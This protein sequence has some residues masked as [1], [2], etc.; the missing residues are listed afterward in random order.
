MARV[1]KIAKWAAI[2]IGG[3][4]AVMIVGGWIL[5]EPRPRGDLGPEADAL[6]SRMEEAVNVEAYE[7]T[8][9]IRWTFAGDHQHLWD[10][11][12]DVARVRWD[13]LEALVH[14]GE[15]SGRVY[16]DGREVGGAEARALLEDAHS[17]FINDSFWLNPIAKLRDRGVT[18]STVE[19]EDGSLALL[20]DYSS[21]GLTP[22]DAYLWFVGHDGLP[23]A[24]KLWVSIIPIGGVRT[25]WED[26]TTLSTGARIARKHEGPLGLTLELSD[27]EGAET[28]GDLVDDPDPFAPLFE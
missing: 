14:T 2:V 9:A 6:A 21:G 13:D 7:R 4:L 8:G 25:T 22:G 20:V 18:L 27:V 10:R 1:Q 12:R 24:W 19:R 28:L 23:E 26:W 3:L 11:E 16:R 17:R 5:H 15:P